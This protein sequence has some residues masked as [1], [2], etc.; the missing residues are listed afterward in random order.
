MRKLFVLL[1][2]YALFASVPIAK[3]FAQAASTVTV[4]GIR[5]PN[6]PANTLAATL[7]AQNVF[8]YSLLTLST[9]GSNLAGATVMTANENI[10]ANCAT[11]A[12]RMPNSIPIGVPI[13]MHN[14]CGAAIKVYPDAT[15]DNWEGVAAGTYITIPSTQL[16]STFFFATATQMDQ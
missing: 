8:A 9:A 13:H 5:G 4:A 15:G 14:S 10:V 11:G 2:L 1:A 6:I 7:S 16:D 3:A 12:M